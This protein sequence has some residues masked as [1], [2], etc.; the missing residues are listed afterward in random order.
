MDRWVAKAKVLSIVISS[1]EGA[2][3]QPQDKGNKPGEPVLALDHL[4]GLMIVNQVFSEKQR[5]LSQQQAS[6]TTAAERKT[7]TLEVN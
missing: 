7:W 1:K 4:G 2:C 3:L 6:L 5:A